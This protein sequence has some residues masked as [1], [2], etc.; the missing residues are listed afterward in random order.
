MVLSSVLLVSHAFQ[1]TCPRAAVQSFV[2]FK[3]LGFV[4]FPLYF[5]ARDMRCELGA[6]IL[7]GRKT[8]T[9]M[10]LKFKK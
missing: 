10:R 2:H 3:A 6:G 5:P 7:N 4:I 8:G 1:S 9:L